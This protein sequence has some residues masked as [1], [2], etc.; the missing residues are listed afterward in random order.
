MQIEPL[1]ILIA[2]DEPNMRKVLGAMLERKGYEVHH[3]SDGL[4]ALEVLEDH[5]IDIIIT[6]YD[7][8]TMNGAQLA[9]KLEKFP[10]ILV[11]GREDAINA[12]KNHPNIIRILIKPYDR[13]DLKKALSAM[14]DKE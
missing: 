2:D 11:S 8:P 6:D 5:H 7:M 3:A 4:G 12:G 10:V 13:H 14:H 9:E 1:Q